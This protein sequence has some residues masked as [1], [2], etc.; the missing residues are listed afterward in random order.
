TNYGH[1]P[2]RAPQPPSIAVFDRLADGDDAPRRTIQ[3]DHTHLG[4]PIKVF[5]DDRANELIVADDQ[6]GVL[7]FDRLAQGNARPVRM[8]HSHSMP[9]GIFVD[10]DRDELVVTNWLT[11]TIEFYPRTWDPHDEH[12]HP[13]HT[14]AISP[15]V[16]VIGIGNP[17]A[18]AFARD[19]IIAPN[20][21][22]HPG[23]AAYDRTANGAAASKRHVEGNKAQMSRSIHGLAVWQH[24]TDPS[25]D[26]VFIPKPLGSGI[27]V[28]NRTDDGN[29]EPKRVIQG[30]DTLLDDADALTV[31]DAEIGV[32]NRDNRILIYPRTG[33]GNIAPSRQITYRAGERDKVTGKWLGPWGEG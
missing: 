21:V 27:L 3:G 8:I 29:V 22:S 6:E 25:E 5:V 20:C 10:E 19:E 17:G 13:K 12:P 33:N 7:V 26:E 15:D 16:P 30:P 32:P 28:F 1:L 11:R 23:F 31:D 18:L 24:P 2:R 4:M 9:S 14:I